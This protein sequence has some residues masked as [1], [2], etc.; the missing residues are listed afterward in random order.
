MTEVPGKPTQRALLKHGLGFFVSGCLAFITDALVLEL[1]TTLFGLAP[2]FARIGSIS[3]AM[4][5]GWLSH[6]RLT[7]AIA[8]APSLPEFGRYAAV[9]WFSAGVNYLVFATIL[10][11][12]P[13]TSPFA[14]LFVA[15]AVA[16]FVSYVGMRYA[17][18]RVHTSPHR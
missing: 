4:V 3:I 2:I 17:A 11:L 18:F 16:M 7:F 9:A 15:S 14:A 6:R 8:A 1:L 13:Q 10:L 5:V 12:L